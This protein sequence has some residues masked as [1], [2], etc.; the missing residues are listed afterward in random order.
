MVGLAGDYL[1]NLGGASRLAQLLQFQE[2]RAREPSGLGEGKATALHWGAWRHSHGTNR[3]SAGARPGGHAPEQFTAARVGS[4]G[5]AGAGSAEC[6]DVAATGVGRLG[7]AL[8]AADHAGARDRVAAGGEQRQG[9]GRSAAVLL[10]DGAA[11][12]AA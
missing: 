8:R 1:A 11:A 7:H 3:G 12:L 4:A 2:N 10:A 6:A 9:G 5:R